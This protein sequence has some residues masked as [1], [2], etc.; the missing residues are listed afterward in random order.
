MKVRDRFHLTYCSNIHAG[1]AWIEVDRAL[2]AI[3]GHL[4]VDGPLAIGLRLSALAAEALDQPATLAGFRAFLK[5]GDY[6]VPTITAF[7]TARFTASASRN[8]ST[9]PTGA[10]RRGWPTRIAW[11]RCSRR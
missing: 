11:P 7:P 5:A 4:G 10:I 2:P 3:R 8:R 6:Y 9:C 1:E